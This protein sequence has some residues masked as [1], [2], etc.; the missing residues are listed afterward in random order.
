MCMWQLAPMI[1]L[2]NMICDW[3]HRF[4]YDQIFKHD[5]LENGPQTSSF[6]SMSTMSIKQSSAC[7]I[8]CHGGSL[9]RVFQVK[10]Q[11]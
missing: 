1:W 3:Q 6:M 7:P 9:E 2:V 10:Y 11:D 5:K 4:A 8:L